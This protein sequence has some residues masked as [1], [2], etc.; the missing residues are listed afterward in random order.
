MAL[1]INIDELIN[2][3]IVE[4][5]RI[6]FK[7]GWNPKAIIHTMCAF[8]NDINDWGGGYIIIGLEEDKGRPIYPPIGIEPNSLDAIQ[9]EL[10]KLSHQIEPNYFPISQPL[11]F[12][13]KHIFIIWIPAGDTR[14]YSAPISP[15]EKS[16]RAYYVRRGSRTVAARNETLRQLI[17]LTAR[18]PFD[19]RVNQK[20]EIDDLSLSLIQAYLKEVKSNLFTESQRIPFKD[21]CKQMSIVRG[22]EENLVPVN[23]GLLFFNDK[24][25]QF[26]NRTRIEVVIHDDDS[27][28]NFIEKEFEGP[29]NQQLKNTLDYISTRVIVEKVVKVSGKAEARRF[30]NYPYEAV[31]EVI[32]NAVFHKGYDQGEP[33]EI[34]V[35]PDRIE[36]LSF[37]GPMPPVDQVMLKQRR[38]ASRKYR[39]RRI[40]DFLKELHL[41]EGRGSGFPLIYRALEENG[42]PY[43]EFVTDDDKT[44]FLAILKSQPE[45][46]QNVNSQIENVEAINFVKHQQ[47]NELKD[48]VAL[49]EQYINTANDRANDRANV[50]DNVRD[51]VRANEIVSNLVLDNQRDKVKKVLRGCFIPLLREN[52]LKLINLKNH[53]G[54]FNRYIKPLIE[55]CWLEMTDPKSPTNPNQKYRTTERGKVLL[56]IIA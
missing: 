14:P 2:G 48:I 29:L 15:G 31:E 8:A 26:L 51:N 56:E 53:S 5:D 17:E 21:L 27:G 12:Q 9:G 43:P 45:F 23:A 36:V 19:D 7:K 30:Y 22:A 4:W 35:F 33:I 10:L 37:P 46:K 34:Q 49:I 39:N 44:Y 28:K 32:T 50:R 11:V 54:N 13:D 41:T 38:V 40:G 6:E 24:P 52:V 47:I 20:A 55:N 42:S 25:H 16:E 1:P 3:R 18:T